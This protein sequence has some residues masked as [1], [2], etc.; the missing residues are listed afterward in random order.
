MGQVSWVTSC[1]QGVGVPMQGAV[2]PQAACVQVACV[3]K[4]LHEV[5]LP[6]HATP[7]QVQPEAAQDVPSLNSK[8]E[9]IAFATQMPTPASGGVQPGG[10]VEQPFAISQLE[11]SSGVPAQRAGL[12]VCIVHPR[13]EEHGLQLAQS[14]MFAG[15]THAWTGVHPAHVVLPHEATEQLAHVA[16]SVP[17][18]RGGAVTSCGGGGT[19]S[20]TLQQT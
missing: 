11:Q 6:L 4:P 5:G 2:Q 18:H 19:L 20:G 16:L 10:Q 1:S 17:V 9:R 13:Q 15:P 3:V 8:H 14:S 7:S 12:V